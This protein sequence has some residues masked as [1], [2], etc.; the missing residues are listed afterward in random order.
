MKKIITFTL[1][2]FCLTSLFAQSADKELEF[3]IQEAKNAE[4]KQMLTA[5]DWDLNSWLERNY[6]LPSAAKAMLLKADIEYKAKQ[7][8]A[9]YLT[10]L[11]YAYEF[12]NEKI[13]KDL[14]DKIIEEFP[15]KQ[16]TELLQALTPKN[17]PIATEDRLN[18]YFTAANKLE[19]KKAQDFLLK[20]YALFFERFPAYENKDKIELLL[21][22]TYRNSGN[23]LAALSKYDK[24][25]QIYPS[26]KY[27][28]A[29]LR[30]KGDIY[31]SELK[32]HALA[33]EYYQRVLKD[34]PNSVEVPTVYK[35]L[36]LLEAD[37]KNYASATEY[38]QK[39]FEEY[40]KDGQ[41][42]EAF[43]TLMFKAEV[44]EKDL[45]N[46]NS[47]VETLKVAANIMPAQEDFYVE[48]K[49]KE[50]KIQAK[51]LKDPYSERAAM[52]EI[53]V[54]FPK[55]ENGVQA[56]YRVAEL[57]ES[58]G[59]NTAA[60]EKYNR[61]ILNRPQSKFAIKA[62]KRIKAIEKA[63]AKAA[64]NQAKNATEQK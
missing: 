12:P 6:A 23:Y 18:A 45:K 43:N 26:T 21:G 53:A 50:A 36:A 39:A 63:E 29:S 64:K 35:H 5:L 16:K 20:D 28:A 42:T 62:Q 32:D 46:Y 49:F 19:I 33:R 22:D 31:A 47:A 10:L 8:T 27:K 52:E 2:L 17:L 15:S 44:Q 7:Y 3:Y 38:A 55:T 51:K 48:A 25:W 37:E 30:M 57:S 56:L 54:S 61:L 34:F 59:E 11:K 13:S 14:A 4:K 41:K 40:L 60:K 24:V 1:C 9:A 58:F